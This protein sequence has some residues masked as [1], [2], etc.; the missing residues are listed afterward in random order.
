[1]ILFLS[2]DIISAIHKDQ[3]DLYGGTHGIR[4]PNILDAALN[5][6]KVQFEGQFLHSSIFHMAA[7][8]G[9]H[10]SE[11]QPFVDGNKRTAGMAMFTFLELNGLEP[12]A[13]KYDYYYAV[14]A[15]ANRKM[16]KEQLADWLQTA[17]DRSQTIPK[18][19]LNTNFVEK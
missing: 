6:P 12:T 1:M 14:M 9:F 2:A 8:Y 18:G 15:V 5:L 4:D 11:G 16:N 17:I 13:T 3:I 7:A 10:I 19:L